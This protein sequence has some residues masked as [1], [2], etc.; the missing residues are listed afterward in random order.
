MD[1]EKRVRQLSVEIHQSL[2]LANLG[3]KAESNELQAQHV[4][5]RC[6]CDSRVHAHQH[7]ASVS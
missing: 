7:I 1:A 6:W 4:S 5:S 3:T 2:L